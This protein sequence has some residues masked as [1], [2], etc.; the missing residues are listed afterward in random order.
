M[1]PP[2]SPPLSLLSLLPLQE[3]GKGR[4]TLIIAHRLSTVKDADGEEK[5]TGFILGV[6]LV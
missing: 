3:I 5:D 1:T 6:A 4:T 2:R